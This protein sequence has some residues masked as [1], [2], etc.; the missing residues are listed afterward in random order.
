[1]KLFGVNMLKRAMEYCRDYAGGYLPLPLNDQENADYF[2]AFNT[3]NLD[4]TINFDG[5]IQNHGNGVVL[6]LVRDGDDFVRR[7]N[8]EQVF[9]FNWNTESGEPSDGS[10][11]EN[12]VVMLTSLPE[13]TPN[14]S[15]KLGTWNDFW[16]NEDMN[17]VCETDS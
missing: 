12:Y 17:I 8:N 5:D 16:S 6:D 10:W 4:T 1:M 13:S 14:K 3:F 7:S 11:G 2:N 9:F 15:M